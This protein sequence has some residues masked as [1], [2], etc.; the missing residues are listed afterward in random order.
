MG[1][2]VSCRKCSRWVELEAGRSPRDF[3]C[4]EC[5]GSG[6][7]S[8]P[9]AEVPSASLSAA[10]SR[11][12]SIGPDSG[13]IGSFVGGV[14]PV[15]DLSEQL[16]QMHVNPDDLK[17]ETAGLDEASRRLADLSHRSPQTESPEL[18]ELRSR[19]VE[20]LDFAREKAAQGLDR[21]RDL[22]EDFAREQAVTAAEAAR[23][24]VEKKGLGAVTELDDFMKQQGRRI[25]SEAI[26]RVEKEL[27]S[28]ARQAAEAVREAAGRQRREKKRRV[29][30]RSREPR[31]QSICKL[32]QDSIVGGD[33]VTTCPKCG[34][35][36]HDQCYKMLGGCASDECKAAAPRPAPRDT[37]PGPQAAETPVSQAPPGE[38][39]TAVRRCEACGTQ[40]SRG[41]LVC[42]QCGRWLDSGRTRN[43]SRSRKKRG[44]SPLGC[45][46]SVLLLAIGV[47]ALLAWLVA[48]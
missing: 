17:I 3:I 5:G 46:S 26:K 40:V 14:V 47:G 16:A 36:Y 35:Q 12:P 1:R 41:T 45:T 21:A 31:P 13:V 22:A 15:T 37:V 39:R 38:K 27:K 7:S 32:C 23:D 19:G 44:N 29:V 4:D 18:A 11:L 33:R 25:G 24:L 42:P 34:S 8:D 9:A 30:G 6:P 48:M 10:G 2:I 28:T 43:D 20:T